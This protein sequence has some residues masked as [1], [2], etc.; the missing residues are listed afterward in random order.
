MV[1]HIFPFHALKSVLSDWSARD[2]RYHHLLEIKFSGRRRQ[3]D[4]YQAGGL[5]RCETP[6]CG[7]CVK[8]FETNPI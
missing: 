7:Y 4:L 2:H 6:Q 1:T 5:S 3:D 8:H